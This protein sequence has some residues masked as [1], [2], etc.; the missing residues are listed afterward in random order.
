MPQQIEIPELG[1][2]GRTYEAHR[3]RIAE[4]HKLW[5]TLYEDTPSDFYIAL[6]ACFERGRSVE[7]LFTSKSGFVETIAPEAYR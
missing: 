3:E 7:T 2:G 5:R 4:A 1:E 6:A